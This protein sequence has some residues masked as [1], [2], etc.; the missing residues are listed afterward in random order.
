MQLFSIAAAVAAA[1]DDADR[2]VNADECISRLRQL[3][4]T[5]RRY[6]DGMAADWYAGRSVRRQSS[7]PDFRLTNL[8]Y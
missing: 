2:F 3:M 7:A 1:D 4:F 5:K 6:N 8:H